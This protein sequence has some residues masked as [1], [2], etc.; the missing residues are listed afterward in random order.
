MP[1][2]PYDPPAE[3]DE[4]PR[5]M[6]LIDPDAVRLAIFITCCVGILAFIGL[7]FV[8]AREFA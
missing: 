2:N 6:P 5:G 3:V 1:I 4:P 8:L 7:V